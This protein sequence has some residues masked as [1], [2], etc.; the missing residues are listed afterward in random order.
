MAVTRG[1]AHFDRNT[2][3]GA[4]G[5]VSGDLDA[6]AAPTDTGGWDF[7]ISKEN[8]EHVGVDAASGKS[9]GVNVPFT[10]L[11]RGAVLRIV[12]HERP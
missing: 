4:A 12:A 10:G 8:G 11:A 9:A 3:P 6:P 2:L 5:G 7:D 1:F